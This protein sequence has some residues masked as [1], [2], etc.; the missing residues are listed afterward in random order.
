MPELL[1][2]G[3]EE[4]ADRHGAFPRLGDD[5]RA[6]LRAAGTV[7]A[8]APGDVLF[9]E[10]DP[11]YDFFVVESGAVAIVQGYGRVIALDV[12]ARETRRPG[13]FAVGGVASAVG[14]GSMA[15]RLVHQ[16]LAL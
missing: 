10:G 13:I 11:G 16:R 12:A 8:V 15:V 6:L 7:R 3:M 1:G 2:V 4:P 9:R 5:Q 14:E